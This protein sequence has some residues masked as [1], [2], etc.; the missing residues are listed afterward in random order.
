MAIQEIIGGASPVSPLKKGKNAAEAKDAS[1]PSDKVRLSKEAQLLYE[2]EQVKRTDEVR[3]RLDS[4]FYASP[5]VTEKIVD[6]LLEDLK[7]SKA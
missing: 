1:A 5:E 2:S 4:G 7:N 3:D 6:G